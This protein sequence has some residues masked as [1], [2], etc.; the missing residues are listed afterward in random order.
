MPFGRVRWELK[1]A[2]MRDLTQVFQRV[3]SNTTW[4]KSLGETMPCAK[5]W[6][7]CVVAAATMVAA[8]VYGM[9]VNSSLS[10]KEPVAKSAADKAAPKKK[11]ASA[12]ADSV[13]KNDPRIS[14][15]S[16]K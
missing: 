8:S 1:V 16:V 10:V 9:Q 13:Q 7:S 5:T 6:A 3:L 11:A 14:A 2:V 4:A 12:G 15:K